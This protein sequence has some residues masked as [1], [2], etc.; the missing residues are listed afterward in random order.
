MTEQ[1]V[2]SPARLAERAVGSAW[3]TILT[4]YYANSI[5]WRLLKAGGLFFFGFFLWAGSNVLLS[6][7][8]GVIFLQYTL[9]YGFVLILYGPFHHLVVIPVYQRLRRDGT[10]LSLGGHLHLPNLSLAL[11]LVLVLTLGTFPVGPMMIDFQSSLGGSA[12]DIA[13]ELACVK[14]TAANGT[15]TV[16][17]H[18]TESQGVDQVVVQSGDK[19][20]A[21]D[22]EA[23]YEFTISGDELQSIAG[24]K[25]F[26]VDL[27]AEDG[28]L[29]RRYTRTLSMIEEG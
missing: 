22:G 5:S 19:T 29:V 4:I 17:C 10:H 6:Y 8:D 11:F 14:D 13:P 15:T 2:E 9:S 24:S 20:L 1:G 21:V 27:L 16:H 3:K 28:T 23:P 25:R 26:R 18:L 12:P 7:L